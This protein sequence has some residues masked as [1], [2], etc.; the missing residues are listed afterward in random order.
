MLWSFDFGFEFEKQVIY[1][2]I[3]NQVKIF[4]W[5]QHWQWNN[6]MIYYI[7]SFLFLTRTLPPI[8]FLA[9]LYFYFPVRVAKANTQT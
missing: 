6:T 2:W 3:G 8:F 9:P 7:Y 5:I 1:E 4:Q